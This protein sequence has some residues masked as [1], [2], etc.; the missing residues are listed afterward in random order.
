MIRTSYTKLK[1]LLTTL[2]LRSG[3]N[4]MIHSALFSLGLIEGGITGFYKAVRETI[5]TDGT[6]IVPTFTYSF[7]RAEVFDV[8]NT[9][10][11]KEIGVF[12]EFIRNKPDSVR[13]SDPLFSKAAIGPQAK[14]LME[15]PSANCFGKNSNYDKLFEK[16]VLFVALG[17]TYST[18]LTGFLHIE[19]IANV[20]YRDDFSFNG[21]SRGLNGVEYDDRATHYLRN[22]K[23][24]G[25]T[26]TNRESMGEL[27]EQKGVSTAL[28]Y[29]YGRH[30]ALRGDAWRDA[31][32]TE[33]QKKPFFMLDRNQYTNKE[34][35]FY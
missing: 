18:G 4:V 21:I 5:G 35:P 24:Y 22:E 27:L 33:L 12:S 2:G 25:D 26:I 15:R 30:M 1:E 7:R 23:I 9:P 19:K 29:G 17:I 8:V 14:E 16:N 20:P 11:S 34:I 32:I 10:S 31:V 13:C 3:D 28:S 6:L